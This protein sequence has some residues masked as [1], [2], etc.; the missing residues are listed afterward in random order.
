MP[1]WLVISGIIGLTL[2]VEGYLTFLIAESLQWTWMD[3]QFT[4]G[5]LVF[6]LVWFMQFNEF[7]GNRYANVENQVF[8]DGKE[9]Y[10]IELF[11]FKLNPISIATL[12]YFLSAIIIAVL[13]I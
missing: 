9:I 7:I 8:G 10:N 11:Q 1:K 5:F 6:I 3:A 2:I 13:S 4:I 12:L